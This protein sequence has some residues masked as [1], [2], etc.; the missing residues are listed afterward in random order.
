MLL[1]QK[2]SEDIIQQFINRQQ[3]I[4]VS[5]PEV[6]VTKDGICPPG[7][8]TDRVKEELGKGANVFALAIVV[9]KKWQQFDVNWV[10][11]YPRNAAIMPNSIIAVLAWHG[12]F[13]SLNACRIIY[14]IDEA[15]PVTKFGFGY[16]TLPEHAETGE[17]RFLLEWDKSTDI[18]SYEIL[19]FSN[20]NGLLAQFAYPLVRYIQNRFRRESANLM[21]HKINS[22]N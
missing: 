21:K 16:G 17:E 6:G 8:G 2:P 5:Y 22:S 18:V 4:P 15:G 7:Y 1:L 11:T 19:A 12:C 10:K 14:I 9:F 13:W 3:S 20:P